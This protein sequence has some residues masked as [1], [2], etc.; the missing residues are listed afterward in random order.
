MLP[1]PPLP[2]AVP[3]LTSAPAP[4]RRIR[5]LVVDDSVV[6][7]RFLAR[8]LGADLG[9]EVVGFAPHGLAALAQAAELRPDAITMD[10][11]MP[12]MDGLA[13]VRE[14]RRLASKAV[15]IM[16]STL[17]GRGAS[18]TIEALLAGANDYVTKPGSSDSM[19]AAFETLRG[20]LIPKIKQF[21]TG[22]E[23]AVPAGDP[24]GSSRPPAGG[25]PYGIVS[26]P[27]VSPPLFSSRAAL[28]RPPC[29]GPLSA[30][31]ASAPALARSQVATLR[32]DQRRIVAIGVSTGGPTAL[33]KLLPALPANFP[34]PIVIVQHMPPIFT[35]QMADRLGSESALEVMEATDGMPLKPGR[36]MVA[37][38]DF[39]LRL[40]RVG[41][42]TVARLDQ[43]ERENS[44]RPAVDVLFRSVADL[45]GGGVLGI[46]LTGMGHD[47]LR[48][49]E[50][51]KAK[52]AYIMA[53]D[54]A[55]SVVWSMPGAVAEAGLANS[56][57]PLDEMAAAIL[58]QVPSR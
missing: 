7:R 6:I 40:Q 26:S 16:C 42:E 39:H 41:Q 51:L 57:L 50:V 44:C 37:P 32:P 35:R 17:T 2:L 14:L 22:R 45:Y 52:G 47:G 56:I 28:P 15:I 54:R 43:G 19:D 36:V 25:K 5:V 21:F 13:T 53:Q 55:T 1:A 12:E 23:F 11:E 10:I 18:S 46:M 9:L 4:G 33:M 3:R 31:S 20:E 34:L 29:S 24:A 58:R 8:I 38:G 30:A 27:P 48:G 49:T